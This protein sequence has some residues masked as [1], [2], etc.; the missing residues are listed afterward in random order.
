MKKVSPKRFS[1][2]VEVA[3]R[4]GA[5][6]ARIIPSRQVVIDES[7]RKWDTGTLLKINTFFPL[8]SY[9]NSFGMRGRNIIDLT[10]VLP[11]PFSLMF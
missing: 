7:V 9:G 3:L 4:A 1:E 10:L 11:F 2:F 5:T 6:A 8:L